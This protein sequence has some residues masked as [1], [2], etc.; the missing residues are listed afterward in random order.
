MA[1]PRCAGQLVRDWDDMT[2]WDISHQIRD[3]N[4]KFKRGE[5]PRLCSVDGCKRNHVAKG[6]CD[7]H[8]RLE[9]YDS[10]YRIG[11]YTEMREEVLT[12]Y[13]HACECCGITNSA[14]LAI[15]HINGITEDD[16]RPVNIY[17][18]LRKRG[19][20]KDNYRILCHNCNMAVRFGRSCPHENECR[21]CGGQIIKDFDETKCLQC[22]HIIAMQFTEREV[23]RARLEFLLEAGLTS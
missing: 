5:A 15:D 19:Y 1:C 8:Y 20:P 17:Q 4:G 14:F 10:N 7:N 21:R 16:G 2:T 9:R 11:L 22:G 3:E 23:E 18:W 13:G 12:A 6:L